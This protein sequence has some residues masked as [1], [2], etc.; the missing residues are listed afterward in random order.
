ML[1]IECYQDFLKNELLAY[2]NGIFSFINNKLWIPK[3][4]IARGGLNKLDVLI[5]AKVFY[6]NNHK[7]KECHYLLHFSYAI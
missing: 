2:T 5:G 7:K 6:A 4:R 1:L 3:A